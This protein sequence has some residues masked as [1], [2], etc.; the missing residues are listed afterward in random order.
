MMH[1]SNRARVVCACTGFPFPPEPGICKD[2]AHADHLVP[3]RGVS[4]ACCPLIKRL[5]RTPFYSFRIFAAT[6]R[7][8][9]PGPP[10][11]QAESSVIGGTVHGT[12][13]LWH[14]ASMS[15]LY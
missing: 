11:L 4:C 3:C 10:S 7:E 14:G 6:Q 15:H 2:A 12:P 1:C 13:P 8:Y 9:F 5:G